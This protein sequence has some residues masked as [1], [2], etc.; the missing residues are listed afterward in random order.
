M[1]NYVFSFIILI[2]VIFSVVSGNSQDVTNSFLNQSVEAINLFLILLGGMAFWGGIMNVAKESGLTRKI[3]KLFSPILDKIFI[4]L[5]DNQRAKE[6]IS[7]NISANLL[8]LGNAAL[9]LGIAAMKEIKRNSFDK[10]SA[11]TDMI[12]M[13]ILNSASMQLI[14]S[15]VATLRLSKGA[16]NPFDIIIA[17]WIVSFLS[18][19]SGIIAV[20]IFS[21][22]DLKKTDYKK[23]Y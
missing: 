9:P 5:K 10:T 15:N 12:M 6:A 22:F 19:I 18:L 20:K 11:S 21:Y 23:Q 14:P 4:N 13:I 3:S 16:K 8:G 1:M 2:S 7:M 17:V